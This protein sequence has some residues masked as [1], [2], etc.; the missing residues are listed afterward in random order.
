MGQLEMNSAGSP[1]AHPN[2]QPKLSDHLCGSQ[3][4]GIG[5]RSPAQNGQGRRRAA[6]G[7]RVL[8]GTQVQ[9]RSDRPEP[10]PCPPRQLPSAQPHSWAP[11]PPPRCRLDDEEQASDEEEQPKVRPLCPAVCRRRSRPPGRVP[12]AAAG[13]C[14]SRPICHA[15]VCSVQAR[16]VTPNKP[17][18]R[19]RRAAEAAAD[20][21][22][23]SLL[24]AFLSLACHKS[25][26]PAQAPCPHCMSYCRH[27][28]DIVKHHGAAI[29]VAAKD[30]VD[31]YKA[32]RAAATAELLTFLLQVG[33]A[34]S[35][36]VARTQLPVASAG[37][38]RPELLMRVGACHA[39]AAGSNADA[40]L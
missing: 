36:W 35:A 15:P 16:K 26:P 13:R 8:R 14:P 11:P 5:R 40:G 37:G 32:G 10:Q 4:A 21:G 39:C 19:K 34:G 6:A 3:A 38:D 1:I 29:S 31:R 33:A 2:R 12:P 9:C 7:A 18:A 22:E 28:A 17:R 23:A 20:A 25:M 24:G 27:P 30:W